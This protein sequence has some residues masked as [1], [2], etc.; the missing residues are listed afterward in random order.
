MKEKIVQAFEGS[1]PPQKRG[2][3]STLDFTPPHPLKT[4]VLFIV[5]SNMESINAELIK[6]NLPQSERILA[7]SE[8]AISQIKSLISNPTIR[9]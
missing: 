8:V 2:A 9:D 4:A 6:R 7:L 1:L 3:N 5:L